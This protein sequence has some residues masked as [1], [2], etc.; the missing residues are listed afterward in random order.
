MIVAS[1]AE[2]VFEIGPFW[3][4]EN[5]NTFR[6][7]EETIG[8]DVEFVSP[9]SLKEVLIL[10]YSVIFKVFEDLKLENLAS[11]EVTLLEPDKLPIIT[12]MEAVELLNKNGFPF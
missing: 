8:L 4:A 9:Q 7:L 1:G 5:E 6:H 10:A 12:Y 2:K 3:R 11:F